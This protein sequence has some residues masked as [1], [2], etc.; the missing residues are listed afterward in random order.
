M[1]QDPRKSG[2]PS[3]REPLRD[4]Q[5]DTW[6]GPFP[7]RD[8]P[9][10]E[11]EDAPELRDLRSEELNNRSGQFW[12]S[13]TGGYKFGQTQS[14]GSPAPKPA[15]TDAKRGK[16][17]GR[18]KVVLG[19]ILGL[20][21]L[22]V[23][24]NWTLF[25]VRTIRVEGSESIPAEEV[26]RLSGLKQGI[27]MMN[28]DSSAVEMGI[29]QNPSLKF[30]YLKKDYPSTVTLAV[31]EREACC[32]MTWNGIL[33]TMDK[34]RYVLYESEILPTSLSTR[35][36]LKTGSGTENDENS[37]ESGIVDLTAA[38]GEAEDQF[39]ARTEQPEESEESEA[40][41]RADRIEAS[42]VRVDGLKVRSG[43]MLGQRLTLES[44]EQQELFTALFLEMRVLRCTELIEQADLSSLNSILLTTRD[45]FTVSLGDG[46]NIHAKLRSM[47]I[48]REELLRR[49]YHSGVINVMLPETPI[50]SPDGA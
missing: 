9:F 18:G 21:V 4:W 34:Q 50:F 44:M 24:M 47:L 10:D 31:R 1:E 6:Y 42:L 38:G 49:G 29:E 39:A 15:E 25:T 46:Q 3:D 27:P 35:K 32:W 20:I 16:R 23:I 5:R 12:E 45:G 19:T 41:S 13:Q 7:V 28:L 43:S 33:Y 48:T 11:P 8:N 2:M 22:G 37:G 17:V 30:R 14:A 26:I 36:N 40:R